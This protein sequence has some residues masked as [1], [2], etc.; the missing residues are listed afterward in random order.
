MHILGLCWI[1]PI[2]SFSFGLGMAFAGSCISAQLYRIGEGLL[3]APVALLGVLIGFAVGFWSWNTIYLSLM[4]DAK[5][6]WLPNELGYAGSLL[7]QVGLIGGLIFGCLWLI[8]KYRFGRSGAVNEDS[9][10]QKIFQQRWS[11][12]IG[13]VLIGLIATVAYFRVGALGVTAEL[14]SISRTVLSQFWEVSRLEGLDRLTGCMTIVKE[15][16]LSNNGVFVLSLVVGSLASALIAGQ[17]KIQTQNIKGLLRIFFG[18]LLMGWGAMVSLGCTVG[19]FL[20]GIMAGAVSGWVFAIFCIVG[21]WLG[22][23]LRKISI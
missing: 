21:A 2:S 3:T 1:L 20:S 8:R 19:V 17:F 22:W 23:Y 12:W 16:I 13:G 18:G 10:F 5:V 14:G 15:T 6:L 7:L 4:Q 9:I 11:T